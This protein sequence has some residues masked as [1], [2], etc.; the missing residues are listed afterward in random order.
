MYPQDIQGGRARRLLHVQG[1]QAQLAV[2]GVR[3]ALPQGQR[4]QRAE[5]FAPTSAHMGVLLLLQEEEVLPRQVAL[6]GRLK[7]S[8]EKTF[9]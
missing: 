5:L 1:M 8:D 6:A 9:N 3:R 2:S 7:R 4:T